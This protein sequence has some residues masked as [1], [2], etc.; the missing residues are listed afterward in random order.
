M[1]GS[2]HFLRPGWRE[3]KKDVGQTIGNNGTQNQRLWYRRGP[4][5][6]SGMMLV[7]LHWQITGNDETQNQRLRYISLRHI[8]ASEDKCAMFVRLP[9]YFASEQ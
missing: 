1:E 8:S 7:R 9:D 2:R 3:Q 5:A 4:R 6:P